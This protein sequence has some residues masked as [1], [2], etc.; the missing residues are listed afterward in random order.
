[1]GENVVAER[2]PPV[3]ATEWLTRRLDMMVDLT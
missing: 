3:P 1:M 2:F